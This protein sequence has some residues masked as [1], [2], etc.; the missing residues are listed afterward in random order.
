MKRKRLSAPNVIMSLRLDWCS[1]AAAKYACEN[2]HYSKCL[3]ASKI[4]KIG[5][6]E[7]EKYLAFLTPFPGT[8][9]MTVVIP[10]EN[11]TD[12]IFG[13][14]DELYEEFLQAVKKVAKILG[15]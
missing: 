6:W 8:P 13:L 4:V 9:G 5:V 15:V 1:Y 12:Y 3:P 10:K 2:W 14:E 7:D 11:H